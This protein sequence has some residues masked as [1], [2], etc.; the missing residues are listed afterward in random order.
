MTTAKLVK[1]ATGELLVSPIRVA[2][3]GS[4]AREHALTAKIAASPLCER[5]VALPGN[6]GMKLAGL[7]TE[8]ADLGDH[9]ALASRLGELK[10]DLVVVGPDDLLA[11]GIVD[12]LEAAGLAVFGPR[13]AA[14]RIEW[15]KAFAKDLDARGRHSDRPAR[16]AQ[17]GRCDRARIGRSAA[18]G[19]YPAVLKFDGLA[20]GKGVRICADADRCPGVFAGEGFSTRAEIR[21]AQGQGEARCKGRA[22]DRRRAIPH[23]ARGESFRA[24]RWQI[25]FGAPEPALA[26]TSALAKAILGRTPAVWGAYSSRAVAFGR[27]SVRTI[28]GQSFQAALLE[29][30]QA[31]KTPFRGLLYAGLMVKGEEYWVL[32]FN[33][34]FGDPETQAILPRLK[35]D[36]LPLLYGIATGGFERNLDACPLRWHSEACVN[37]VAASRGYPEK[38]ETGFVITGLETLGKEQACQLYYA[39]VKGQGDSLVTSGGRVFGVSA[40]DASLDLARVRALAASR[41]GQLR[42]HPFSEWIIGSVY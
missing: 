27:A 35:S 5:V 7:N 9:A 28:G 17:V 19:G 2:V 4:G 34:R 42:G 14:A 38:P 12:A 16:G 8:A 41:S 1:K 20:L 37:I 11:S 29:K 31:A 32:E 13:K 30:L 24:D 18:V 21:R 40:L 25:L 39:G 23:R 33:A 10:I 15:S 6:D 22:K 3:L 26:T 36:L